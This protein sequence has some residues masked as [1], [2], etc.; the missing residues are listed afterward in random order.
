MS[1]DFLSILT[2]SWFVIPWYSIGILAAIWSIYDMITTNTQVNPPL[3]V[4]WPVIIVFFSVIGLIF[5]LWTCRPANIGQY[6]GKKEKEVHH[7]EVSATWKKVTGSVIHCVGGDGLGIMTAMV[8]SRL[9]NF[10]FWQ[11]FLLEYATGYAFGWFIFQLWAFKHMG[12]STGMALLKGFRAEFFSMFTVMVG[13]G[14][15]MKFV[16]P[17]VTGTPPDPDSFAFWGF[18]SLGLLVGAI[19]TYPMNWWMVKIHWK[20][21]MS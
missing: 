11:E 19:F 12:E 5:Y 3:K 13:M 17:A 21:G 1:V 7:Q 9:H 10:S 8:Y 2:K 6:H 18:G 14:L 15:V 16:T 4:G 20:H